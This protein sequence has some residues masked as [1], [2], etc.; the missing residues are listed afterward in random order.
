MKNMELAPNSKFF[1]E[2]SD[3]E[4]LKLDVFGREFVEQS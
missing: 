2:F 4:F 3:M 1:L